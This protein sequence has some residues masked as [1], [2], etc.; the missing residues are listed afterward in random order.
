MTDRTKITLGDVTVV[1]EDQGDVLTVGAGGIVVAS[2]VAGGSGT[3]SDAI[4]VN[5]DDEIIGISEKTVPV[6]ADL[7]IIEDSEA[8]Y[9]KKKLQLA[10]L[11]GGGG[12]LP[13][14]SSMVRV[15]LSS[16]Q[17]GI[18]TSTDTDIIFDT[19]AFDLGNEFNTSTGVFTCA[20][21]GYYEI[22]ARI[23]WDA[24]MNW[25]QTQIHINE[26]AG[27]NI[28]AMGE[29]IV[30]GFG[31]ACDI[32]PECT[33]IA[34]LDAGDTIKVVGWHNKGTDAFANSGIENT[35]LIIKKI[36]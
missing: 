30:G 22:Y 5:V 1:G 34:D 2:G 15:Y 4:H 20:A 9:A 8:S 21:D 19:E 3:D 27:Y 10:N 7:V 29:D 31:T 24:T 16:D 11:P 35:T 12:D 23:R 33:V 14:E 6:D 13:W 26:G 28:Y 17:T 25:Y 32:T 18:V 36:I